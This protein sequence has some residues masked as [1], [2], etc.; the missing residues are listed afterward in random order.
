MLVT[1]TATGSAW[2]LQLDRNIYGIRC[3]HAIL[4]PLGNIWVTSLWRCKREWLLSQLNPCFR[5]ALHPRALLALLLRFIKNCILS[6]CSTAPQLCHAGPGS[7]EP[8][9]PS[10]SI[11]IFPSSGEKANQNVSSL[12]LSL[13]Q[14]SLKTTDHTALAWM[15]HRALN[16]EEFNF[17]KPLCMTEYVKGTCTTLAIHNFCL[18]L[19]SLWGV[20]GSV[21]LFD[22][23]WSRLVESVAL[24]LSRA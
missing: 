8:P 9:L 12:E 2:W 15:P 23:V 10:C 22:V 14:P 19:Q 3:V 20:E 17:G 24:S 7:G 21:H 11:A 6:P 13:Y 4:L 18:T 1:Y 16:L 5:E